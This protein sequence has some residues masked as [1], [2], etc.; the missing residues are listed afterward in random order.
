MHD[1]VIRKGIMNTHHDTLFSASNDYITFES[2][3]F[4]T[5]YVLSLCTLM[6]E[7]ENV[8]CKTCVKVKNIMNENA[9]ARLYA[10][11]Q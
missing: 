6:L 4:F 8:S 9:L 5:M 3:Q 11:W 2:C 7:R 1:V 10:S